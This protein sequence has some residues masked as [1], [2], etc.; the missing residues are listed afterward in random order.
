MQLAPRPP[1]LPLKVAA[2]AFDSL[3]V[4][5]TTNKPRVFAW[6]NPDG[7]VASLARYSAFATAAARIEE[8]QGWSAGLDSS[9]NLLMEADA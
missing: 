7:D 3:S 9:G 8:A 2:D 5:L 6:L 4:I 1:P